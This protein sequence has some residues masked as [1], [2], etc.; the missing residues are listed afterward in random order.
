MGHDQ[1]RLAV[2]LELA[3][4]L[5]ALGLERLVAD[6]DDLVDQQDVGIHVD[7]DGEA[8]ADVHARG[9]VADRVV[10]EVFDT[11]EGN[12]VVELAVDL[13]GGEPEDRPVEVDVLAAREVG[14]EAGADLEQGADAALDD[15]LPR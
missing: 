12:D 9:V 13:P 15:D 5:H 2:V 1:D 11:G 7:R 6:G 10:D 14:V 3:D 4:P 8:E